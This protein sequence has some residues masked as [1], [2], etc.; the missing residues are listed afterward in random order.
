MKRP[1][2]FQAWDER[3]KTMFDPMNDVCTFAFNCRQ[4]YIHIREFTGLTDKNGKEIYEGNIIKRIDTGDTQL[5]VWKEDCYLARTIY[6]SW[7]KR[8]ILN[9]NKDVSLY[10]MTTFKIEVIGNIYENPELLK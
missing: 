8:N 3:T 9:Q 5:I 6:D 10:S 7:L 4:D 2:K 1:I